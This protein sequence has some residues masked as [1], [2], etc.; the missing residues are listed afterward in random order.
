V[1]TCLRREAAKDAKRSK[2]IR[3]TRVKNFW[4]V[5]GATYLLTAIKTRL[6]EIPAQLCPRILVN[7]VV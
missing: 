7:K 3:V 6:N 1:F 4:A 2:K 5:E